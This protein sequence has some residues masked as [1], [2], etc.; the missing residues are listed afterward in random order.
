MRTRLWLSMILFLA[1][2]C[3][4]STGASSDGGTGSAAIPTLVQHVSTPNTQSSP[5][6]GGL[7]IPLPN[8]SLAGN[9]LIVAVQNAVTP[10]VTMSVSD[11]MGN[12]YAAGPTAPGTLGYQTLSLFYALNAKAGVNKVTVTFAGGTVN[13]VAATVSEFYDVAA[14]AAADGDTHAE[15]TSSATTW[16]AGSFTPTTD[17]DLIYQVAVTNTGIPYNGTSYTAGSGFSFLST[18]LMDGMVVQYHIQ[19]TAGVINPT[20]AANPAGGYAAVAIALKAASTGTAPAAGIRVV[21]VQH[22]HVP[23]GTAT[24]A[25]QFPCTGNLI[26]FAW[27]EGDAV[28]YV[29]G[30]TDGNRN[31]Y[32]QV[33]GS[34]L[35]N[36]AGGLV[37]LFYAAN[38]ITT[39]TMLGPTL[40]FT[41]GF[42]Y[43][44]DGV[45]YDVTGAAT[46]P[47]DVSTTAMGN[48]TVGG[49]LVTVSLTPAGA[50]ELVIAVGDQNEAT[51]TGL[52]GPGF[53]FD[54]PTWPTQDELGPAGGAGN[55]FTLDAQSGHRYTIDGNSVTFVWTESRTTFEWETAAAA[56]K[57]ASPAHGY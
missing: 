25:L 31:A 42:R 21:R 20:L 43:G 18:D 50:G 7:T 14:V 32:A 47:F 3:R 12:R 17:G 13:N 10:G 57:A 6:V 40:A 53:W 24:I 2:A 11:N 4:T 16:A 35:S 22:N 9:C 41:G 33:A 23:G 34:P 39:P 29:T 8:T 49:D 54:E 36:G 1:V 46:N 15:V 28:E 5:G 55:R 26:V 37:Q 48:Q 30:V 45:L 51:I 38:A 56:F 52:V 27:H 44:S 19:T